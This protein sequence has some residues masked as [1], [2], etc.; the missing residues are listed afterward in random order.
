MMKA[1]AL[2]E[3]LPLGTIDPME[4]TMRVLQAQEQPNWEKL[5]PGM[6]Q[7]GQPQKQEQPDPK[8]IEMQQ[9]MQAEQ[10]KAGLRQQEIQQKMAMNQQSEEMKLAMKAQENQ[11]ELQNKAQQGQ[12]DAEIAK[13]KQQIFMA[14][15][16]NKL[17][18]NRAVGEQKIRQAEE[19]TKSK[20]RQSGQS[21]KTTK[22]PK[23]SK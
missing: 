20:Q 9:K 1:M 2:L 21:G 18:V 17:T 11:L 6:A 22:S 14:D 19:Q 3:L 4:V 12:L 5:I 13:Q 10:Q 23:R 7:T 8:L 16:L 15:A